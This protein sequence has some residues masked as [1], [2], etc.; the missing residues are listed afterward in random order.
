FQPVLHLSSHF[1]QSN[2][3]FPN[4]RLTALCASHIQ[5][6]NSA[7]PFNRGRL[8]PLGSVIQARK[9]SAQTQ[10]GYSFENSVRKFSI[11]AR[12]LGVAVDVYVAVMEW[13][14]VEV[15]G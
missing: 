6:P 12:C 2:S 10:Q 8:R 7:R 13:R 5:C 9:S 1:A 15:L 3:S 14:R 11:S 4:F